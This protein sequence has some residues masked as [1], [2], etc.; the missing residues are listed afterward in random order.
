MQ[1]RP[2]QKQTI[3]ATWDWMTKYTGNPCIVL[4]TGA[5]KSVVIAEMCHQAV[6]QWDARILVLA[7]QMEL[8]QQ[9]AEKMISI[10]PNAP[11]GIYS[12]SIGKRTIDKI[13][14][15]GIQSVRGKADIIGKRDLVFVDEAHLI[16]HKEDGAYRELIAQ[17]K[18]MNQHMRV[19]GFTASP[20]RLGFG[21]ITQD[22]AI[23]D[24]LIEIA[25]IQQ[26]QAQGFLAKLKSKHTNT[27]IDVSKVH[28]RGGEYI[29]SELQAAVDTDEM[30]IPIVD[31]IILRAEDRRSWLIFCAGVEH[32]KHIAAMMNDRGIN[33]ECVT[34]ETTKLERIRIIDDFKSGK[35]RCLTNA[36]VLTT[37]FDAPN[38][39]L[40]AFLRPTCS[41]GL[42]LQMA[43]RGFRLKEHTDHC[44]VL[45]FA[46]LIETHGPVTGVHAPEEKGEGNGVPP[47]KI[48]PECDEIIPAQSQECPSCGFIFPKKT[49]EEQNESK[50]HLRNDDI[51]GEDDIEMIVTAWTWAV[52]TAKSGN[53][54]IVVSYYGE[55]MNARP[56]KEYLCVYHDGYAGKMAKILFTEIL[57]R[58]GISNPQSTDEIENAPHP[59]LIKYKKDGKFFRVTDRIWREKQY[60]DIIPF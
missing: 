49:D 16:N 20:F 21:Q 60:D 35:I 34:G 32:S 54:M 5:G 29:E 26:L 41:P 36:N 7:H 1:L 45:D 46:G 53:N 59:Y 2:Y 31:E 52:Q 38:V 9:N 40:I 37:G 42:Y 12:A 39:D 51:M 25:T 13:T 17:L 14:F 47:S 28:R 56:I 44:L 4:P 6:K 30:N 11:V 15:A 43:G 55:D 33:T 24:D 10:W 50:L 23:F 57:D 27:I 18:E 58:V 48:C 22:G 19:V 8:L 3:D